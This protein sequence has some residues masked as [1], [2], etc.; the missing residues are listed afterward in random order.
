MVYSGFCG[1][2]SSKSSLVQLVPKSRV[3]TLQSL[4]SAASHAAFTHLIFSRSQPVGSIFFSFHQGQKLNFD[5]SK[6]F[7]QCYVV[8]TLA[9]LD[10]HLEK[11]G[12]ILRILTYKGFENN[13]S[14]LFCMAYFDSLSFKYRIHEARLNPEQLLQII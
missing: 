11:A 4:N 1:Y 3:L 9:K 5:A 13:L 2:K 6:T 7:R 10:I 12:R 14:T 8:L